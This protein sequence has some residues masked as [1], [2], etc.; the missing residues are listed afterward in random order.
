MESA[1]TSMPEEA[2]EGV[3][4]VEPFGAAVEAV[5]VAAAAGEVLLKRG[6]LQLQS[7]RKNR[8]DR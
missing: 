2:L 1:T 5:V 3:A 7:G 6:P 8:M 4:V